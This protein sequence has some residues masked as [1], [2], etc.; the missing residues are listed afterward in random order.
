MSALVETHHQVQGT[1]VLYLLPDEDLSKGAADMEL[2]QRLEVALIHWTRQIKEVLSL[3]DGAGAGAEKDTGGPLEELAF[4]ASRCNDLSGVA[5]QLKS[6][7]VLKIVAVLEAF[8]SAYLA[9]FTLLS[10][11]IARG[12]NEASENLKLLGVL[13]PACEALAGAKPGEV[14]ALLPEI[15]ARIRVVSAVSPFYCTV[16]RITG[17]LRRVS[18]EVLRRCA[19]S[20]A[21]HEVFAGD[22]EA[23]LALLPREEAPPELLTEAVP[24]LL[25]LRRM[26]EARA[27]IEAGCAR[28]PRSA[29]SAVR[30]CPRC[31]RS[32]RPWQ[33]MT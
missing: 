23:A 10:Q 22:P 21:V 9:P 16:E 4:Y 32:A 20:I 2:C 28:W 11:A 15:L 24:A 30:C 7:R 18:N 5:A 12:F 13:K 1:T 14:P 33:A 29:R 19:S 6:E 27:A 26:D 3:A 25:A 17:L 8:G 31:R